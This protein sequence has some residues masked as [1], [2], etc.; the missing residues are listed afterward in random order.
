MMRFPT[1]EQAEELKRI[2]TDRFVRIKPG[3]PQYERFLGKIGRVVTVNY[4]GKALVDF[5]DGAWYDIPASA[6]YLEVVPDEQAQ[7]RYDPTINSAQRFP[8]RQA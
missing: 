2:W 6:E 3:F 5:A 4:S 8:S 7:G 1:Y